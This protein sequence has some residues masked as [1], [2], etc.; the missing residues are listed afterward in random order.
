MTNQTKTFT[1]DDAVGIAR[2]LDGYAQILEEIDKPLAAAIKPYLVALASGQS[3][4]NGT[5]WDALHAAAT[6]QPNGS[7]GTR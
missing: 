1:I 5:V 2:N 7:G 3:I 4:D 6:A